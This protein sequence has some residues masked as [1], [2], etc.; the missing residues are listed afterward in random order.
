MILYV[1][2]LLKTL[3]VSLLPHLVQYDGTPVNNTH[4][5]KTGH[6]IEEAVV[7]SVDRTRGVYLSCPD[8]KLFAQ[9][10]ETNADML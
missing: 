5:L 8:A 4:G 2:P 10:S 7:Q 1:H 9:V 3:S 6:I